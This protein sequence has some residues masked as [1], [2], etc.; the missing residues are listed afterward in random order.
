M[1]VLLFYI[2]IN[3]TN[4]RSLKTSVTTFLQWLCPK[5][6][7]STLNAVVEEFLKTVLACCVQ[8]S[9]FFLLKTSLQRSLL[10]KPCTAVRDGD[11]DA[12]KVEAC[13]Y[14]SYSERLWSDGS[15]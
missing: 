12:C 7:G 1:N 3:Y 8:S 6:K 14:V 15:S 9:S 5:S 13:Y 2:V 4:I 11:V 10:S